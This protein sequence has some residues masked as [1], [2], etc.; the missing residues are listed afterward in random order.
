M[1]KNGDQ[2][3]FLPRKELEVSQNPQDEGPKSSG[4]NFLDLAVAAVVLWFAWKAAPMLNHMEHLAPYMAQE[5]MD[6][7]Q[8]LMYWASVLAPRALI[9]VSV[10]VILDAFLDGDLASSGGAFAIFC[11]APLGWWI[12]R[13]YHAALRQAA[14]CNS[15][16]GCSEDYPFMSTMFYDLLLA[17]ATLSCLGVALALVGKLLGA[18][19]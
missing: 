1:L 18:K 12:G 15:W 5:R 16:F 17:A 4:S 14:E 10:V 13:Q 11:M 3:N 2:S 8:T 6:W 19:R 9:F 7:V